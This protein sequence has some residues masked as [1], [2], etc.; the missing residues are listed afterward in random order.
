MPDSSSMLTA[1]KLCNI[2][3]EVTK[4]KTDICSFLSLRN[5][6]NFSKIRAQAIADCGPLKK[7]ILAEYLLK[8]IP[9]VEPFSEYNLPLEHSIDLKKIEQVVTKCI[10]KE[11]KDLDDA[12]EFNI[13]SIKENVK[14]MDELVNEFKKSVKSAAASIEN[15]DICKPVNSSDIVTEF[16]PEFVSVTN[17]TEHIEKY[18]ANFITQQAESELHQ[19]LDKQKF[20]VANSSSGWSVLNYGETYKY[21]GSPKTPKT[22]DPIPDPIKKV[23]DG[24]R[25][26]YP[27]CDINQCTINKYNDNNS[28]LSEHSDDEVTLKP[29]SDIFTVS[30]GSQRDI[31]F[32]DVTTGN[33]KVVTVDSRSLYIMSLPSQFLWTHRMDAADP[34]DNIINVRYSLTFRCVGPHYRNSCII[35]GD[36][37]TKRL[38]FGNT[39][40]TF[41]DKLPGKRVQALTIEDIDPTACIGYRN[42]I[43][44]VGL[45]NLKCTKIPMLFSDSRNINVYNK[46]MMLREKIDYIRSL[47]PKSNIVVSPILPTKID[48]LNQRALEFNRYLFEYLCIVDVKSLNFDTFL[49]ENWGKLNDS[50]GCYNSNDK[51]HLGRNGIRTLAKLIKDEVL[52]RGTNGRSFASV[53]SDKVGRGTTALS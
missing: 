35:L 41:R 17:P 13:K 53:T 19:F 45:N 48:W 27:N 10:S 11:C 52:R 8:I 26:Q 40:G 25:S 44:H 1:T 6:D 43:I 9:L 29:E 14:K 42:I 22:P 15:S 36:S 32:R 50:Y 20:D 16:K 2:C 3:N 47:C 34:G 21:T 33:E 38:M 5:I 18:S 51:I 37:N 28:E 49:D 46:F 4:I 30:V 24:I 31:K 12:N 39:A 23:M 7:F